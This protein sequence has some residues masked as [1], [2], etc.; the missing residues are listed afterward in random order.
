MTERISDLLADISRHTAPGTGVSRLP[1]TPEH[2]A[3]LDTIR[4]WMEKAGLTVTVD[5]AG[6]MIGRR[7]GPQGAPVLLFGSHQD[8]VKNIGMF[9]GNMGVLLPVLA[10]GGLR[11]MALPFRS[12]SLPLQTKK[13]A[14]FRQP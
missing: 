3:A 14:V 4:G 13:G 10:L 2:R 6:T 12:R 11:D 9:D 5:A 1:F 7:E 8:S